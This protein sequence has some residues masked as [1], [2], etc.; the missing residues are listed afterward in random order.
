VRTQA[1]VPN[2]LSRQVAFENVFELSKN[3]GKRQYETGLVTTSG[4]S[5]AKSKPQLL[6]FSLFLLNNMTIK[7]VIPQ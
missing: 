3:T 2:S 1:V 5:G 7:E 6:C 4:G